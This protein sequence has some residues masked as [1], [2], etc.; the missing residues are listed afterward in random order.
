MALPYRESR[1]ICFFCFGFAMHTYRTFIN[2]LEDSPTQCTFNLISKHFFNSYPK[3][4]YNPDEKQ[5]ANDYEDDR[6]FVSSRTDLCFI[7]LRKEK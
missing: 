1:F 6:Q 2:G 5:G 3:H 4:S 7:L